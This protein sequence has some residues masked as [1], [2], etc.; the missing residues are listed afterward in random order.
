MVARSRLPRNI[1]KTT[2]RSVL[3][4]A[5]NADEHAERLIE[6]GKALQEVGRV[7]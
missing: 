1:R 3:I 5:V 6:R 4:E 2:T 7:D